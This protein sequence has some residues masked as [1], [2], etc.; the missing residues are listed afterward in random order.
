MVHVHPEV[1]GTAKVPPTSVRS[2]RDQPNTHPK[3]QHRHKQ[4][5]LATTTRNKH[6]L[7]T[8]PKLFLLRSTPSPWGAQTPKYTLCKL[9]AAPSDTMEGSCR[10]FQ[11]RISNFGKPPVYLPSRCGLPRKN[12]Y[13]ANKSP[14]PIPQ[15]QN[16]HKSSTVFKKPCI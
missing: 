15:N 5:R 4:T 10:N 14:A 9:F 3:R 8:Q 12:N 16:S 7:E 13:P 6:E 11:T 1:Y 2:T